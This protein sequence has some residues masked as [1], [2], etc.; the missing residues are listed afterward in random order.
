MIAFQPFF[1][2][3]PDGLDL[4]RQSDAVFDHSRQ[5][6]PKKLVFYNTQV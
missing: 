3:T 4:L 6:R 2:S 5:D 1:L